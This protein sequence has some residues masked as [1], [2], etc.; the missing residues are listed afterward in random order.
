MSPRDPNSLGR[1]PS[2]DQ[3]ETSNS[4]GPQRSGDQPG[5]PDIR[6]IRGEWNQG[7]RRLPENGR[8]RRW[9]NLADKALQSDDPPISPGEDFDKAGD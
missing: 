2:A 5:Q 6:W 9:M 8:I 1:N 3:G 7:E 4:P